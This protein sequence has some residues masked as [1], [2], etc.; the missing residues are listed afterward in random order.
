VAVTGLYV[1]AGQL[2]HH[3]ALV[4]EW[5]QHFEAVT[6]LAWVAVILLVAEAVM[7]HL[8]ARRPP[9]T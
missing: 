9:R 3:Y 7:R 6:G 5:P 4:L 1:T 8:Q 2:N